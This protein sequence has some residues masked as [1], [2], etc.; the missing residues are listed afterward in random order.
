MVLV[1]ET[2]LK[3]TAMAT[4]DTNETLSVGRPRR[5]QQEK[6][7]NDDPFLLPVVKSSDVEAMTS[8]GR[9]AVATTSAPAEIHVSS[10]T[11]PDVDPLSRVFLAARRAAALSEPASSERTN[12][13]GGPDAHRNRFGKGERRLR[14]PRTAERQSPNKRADE[15]PANILD[16]IPV[17]TS[18]PAND[19]EPEIEILPSGFDSP[20]PF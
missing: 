1:P 13:M 11:S 18:T 12:H 14:L 19:D 15:S 7:E 2:P 16:A 10:A 5:S 6:T 3:V 20:I 17:D 9:Q 4:Y 8:P